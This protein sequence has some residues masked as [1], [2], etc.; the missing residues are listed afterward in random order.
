MQQKKVTPRL[1]SET[2]RALTEFAI[3]I[4]LFLGILLGTMDYAR[5]MT[6]NTRLEDAAIAAGRIA[7]LGGSDCKTKVIEEFTS[8]LS[9]FGYERSAWNIQTPIVRPF[10]AD[11][12]LLEFEANGQAQFYR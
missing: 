2:G 9:D 11:T 6:M 12:S 8:K 10:L 1:V 4:P 3:V 7:S 5:M